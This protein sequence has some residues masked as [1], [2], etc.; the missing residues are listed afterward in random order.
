MSYALSFAVANRR[1]PCFVDS[2]GQVFPSSDLEAG[3]VRERA[4]RVEQVPERDRP[5]KA[6]RGA[7]PSPRWR[8]RHT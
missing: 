5:Q 1:N 4:V 7:M 8:M 6:R 2:P 3:V